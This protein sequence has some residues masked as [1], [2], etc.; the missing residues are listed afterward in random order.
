MANECL[1]TN[2]DLFSK[3]PK[4]ISIE[5]STAVE[6]LATSGQFNDNAISFNL[7]AESGDYL[8]LARLR[9]Y[10][11]VKVNRADKSAMA[12]DEVKL[13]P[14]WPSALWSQVDVW[15]GETL[16]ST[17]SNM[18]P[19]RSYLESLLSYPEDVK[20]STLA[21]LEHYNGYSN[22]AGTECETEAFF[23][24]H[25]ELCQQSRHL[26]NGVRVQFRFIRNR[27]DFIIYQPTAV[28]KT[29][30]VDN[31]DQTVAVLH[32]VSI[33]KV[34]LFV[35]KVTPTPSVI[36]KHAQQLHHEP[37]LYPIDRIEMKSFPISQ[38]RTDETIPNVFLGQLP[39]RVFIGFVD[40]A[41]F[42]GS[43]TKNPFIF[44]NL[45]LNYLAL[46]VNGLLYP[47][48]PFTPNFEKKICRREYAHLLECALGQCQDTASLGIKLD[49]YISQGKTLYGF[50]LQSNAISSST[51]VP[52][53]TGVINCKARFEKALP[54]NITVVIFAEFQSTIS[55]DASRAVYLDY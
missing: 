22:A 35:H 5:R 43:Q 51:V 42:N 29:R 24:L 9:M 2:F 27:N 39:T 11:K 17:S 36:L 46:T 55:I 52:N 23:P 38:G 4:D 28:T 16:V 26:I 12:A 32:E 20:A 21:S 15:L 48:S 50:V 33:E 8:D 19:Y 53:V 44:E 40:S 54:K 34:S 18:Y 7:P 6:V 45:D 13:I 14:C 31:V 41:A 30:K 25:L 37:A 49:D 1:V 10:V 3:L 47:S